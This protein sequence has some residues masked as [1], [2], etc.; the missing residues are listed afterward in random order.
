MFE[1]VS[2]RDSRENFPEFSWH[3][4]KTFEDDPHCVGVRSLFRSLREFEMD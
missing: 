1:P 2:M 3:R 4:M